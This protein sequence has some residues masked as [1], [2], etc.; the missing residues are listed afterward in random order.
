LENIKAKMK[1]RRK[2]LSRV[3]GFI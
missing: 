1:A 2:M 3:K